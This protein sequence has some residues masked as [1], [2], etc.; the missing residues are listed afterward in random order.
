MSDPI[1]EAAAMLAAHPD[2]MVRLIAER[3]AGARVRRRAAGLSRDDV[4]RRIGCR[5]R[6]SPTPRH[7][8]LG[9]RR[10]R[11]PDCWPKSPGSDRGKS[12]SICPCWPLFGMLDADREPKRRAMP[13][14][15]RHPAAI[16][17]A[18]SLG[19]VVCKQQARS[20]R[21]A[22]G[23]RRSWAAE[24]SSRPGGSKVWGLRPSTGRE[25]FRIAPQF[26]FRPW[27]C[28]RPRL[29]C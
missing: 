1:T 16:G 29:R 4:A 12:G 17:R 9:C 3:L 21:L 18:V 10:L 24:P 2:P 15:D 8:G 26:K 25:R 23:A 22:G 5:G 7:S 27:R 19:A 20:P 13:P 11:R 6:S 28:R 14:T